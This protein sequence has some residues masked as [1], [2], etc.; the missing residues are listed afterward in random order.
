MADSE[1]PEEVASDAVATEEAQV[2]ETSETA[3]SA[4][5]D[6]D[7]VVTFEDVGPCRKQANITVKKE[8]LDQE[9]SKTYRELARTVSV[10][11]FRP[12][13][14]PRRVLERKFGK[15]VMEDIQESL[16]HEVLEE[17]SGEAD[18]EPI[19]HL[20]PDN[21]EFAEGALSFSCAFDIKPQ[22]ELPELEGLRV[23]K[24]SVEVKDT[25]VDEELQG[26]AASQAR[27]EKVEDGV[28]DGDLLVCDAEFAGE[29]DKR[30]DDED[31][32]V[33]ADTDNIET[34]EVPG[35]KEAAAGKAIDDVVEIEATDPDGAQGTM[36]VTIREI[37]RK[38]PPEINDEWA[39]EQDFDDL[40]AMKEHYRSQ[41]IKRLEEAA[42]E[43]VDKDLLKA[44]CENLDFEL[45]ESLI[46]RAGERAR[47]E[48]RY[49]LLG[50][51]KSGEELDV[52]LEEFA[53][54]IKADAE[55]QIRSQLLLDKIASEQK[56]FVTEDEIEVK[57]QEVAMQTGREVEAIRE[58]YEGRGLT[59]QLRDE[60]RLNRAKAYLKE[61]AEIVDADN[62]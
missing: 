9:L 7:Y 38:V 44:V 56:I 18:F 23:V 39:K 60:I 55:F 34:F 30:W 40:K 29:G 54:E 24:G 11:G 16:P 61:K 33:D 3:E 47:L 26:L 20:H 5:E 25:V 49:K 13:R 2:E 14:V 50:E 37:K 42:E 53:E 58:Y 46:E 35:W 51:G 17:I 52:A 57:F 8:R 28:K 32:W 43:E 31:L 36:K 6:R 19:G 10:R 12:G 48:K 41:E 62:Q 59:A 27:Y 1:T 4:N 21:I 45:P 22:F 15:H